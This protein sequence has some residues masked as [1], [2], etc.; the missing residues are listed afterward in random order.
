[1]STN[2]EIFNAIID[3]VAEQEPTAEGINEDQKTYLTNRSKLKNFIFIQGGAGSGKTQAVAKV[4]IELLKSTHPDIAIVA[5]APED[6]QIKGIS[7]AL[8]TTSNYMFSDLMDKIHPDWRNY[9]QSDFT[10]SLHMAQ[11]DDKKIN[12]STSA[13]A[14][15][16]KDA[17]MKVLVIDEATFL[18]ERELQILS[19]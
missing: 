18:S 10:D 15:F 7:D 1:L 2:P 16:A 11:L 19:K 3:G 9:D 14:I 4:L 17:D 12:I 6:T 13:T 5:A 8:G